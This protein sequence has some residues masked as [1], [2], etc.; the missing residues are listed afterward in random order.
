MIGDGSVSI[1]LLQGATVGLHPARLT[2]P[3]RW[4]QAAHICWAALGNRGLAV[5]AM[6]SLNTGTLLSVLSLPL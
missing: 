4:W 6:M 1:P 2:A 3:A 5:V